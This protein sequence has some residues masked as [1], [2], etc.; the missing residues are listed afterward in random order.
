MKHHL[1]ENPEHNFESH[2]ILLSSRSISLE[3]II[4]GRKPSVGDNEGVCKEGASLRRRHY[5]F[6]FVYRRVPVSSQYR[7]KV[8]VLE[9]IYGPA[10]CSLCDLLACVLSAKVIKLTHLVGRSAN[11]VCRS[12]VVGANV[13]LSWPSLYNYNCPSHIN[14]SILQRLY[15]YIYI[16][17]YIY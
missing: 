14:Q 2:N 5:L 15:I 16:Y 6:F 17:I 11:A 3:K 7:P 13:L 12:F 9:M 8:Y 4:T 10:G 1:T